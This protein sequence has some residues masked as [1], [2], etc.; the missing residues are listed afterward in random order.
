MT[1][2]AIRKWLIT[3]IFSSLSGKGPLAVTLHA[4][5]VHNALKLKNRQPSVC[6][7]LK[8]VAKHTCGVCLDKITLGQNVKAKA[9]KGSNIWYTF[10]IQ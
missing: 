2:D 1:A 10:T 6:N 7:A 4:G 9:A 8:T 5:T 3:E